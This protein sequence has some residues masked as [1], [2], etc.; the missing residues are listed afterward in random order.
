MGAGLKAGGGMGIA[1]LGWRGQRSAWGGFGLSSS[2]L[3]RTMIAYGCCERA[4]KPNRAGSAPVARAPLIRQRGRRWLHRG[5]AAAALPTLKRANPAKHVDTK[6]SKHRIRTCCTSA[7]DSASRAEV[8]SSRRSSRG[9]RSRQRAMA[10]RWR[11][12]PERR[13]PRSPTCR[14]AGGWKGRVEGV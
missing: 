9:L 2:L 1:G 13:C 4:L 11:W 10:R 3:H 14:G 6:H 5:G 12:P 7:S 8:A